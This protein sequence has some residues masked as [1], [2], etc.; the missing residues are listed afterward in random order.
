MIVGYQGET[1]LVLEK[2]AQLSYKVTAC[3]P[4]VT[5]WGGGVPVIPHPPAVGAG[6]CMEL[7]RAHR[8]GVNGVDLTE[9]EDIKKRW[10]EYTEEL[11][12]KIFRTQIT[13]M[14]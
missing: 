4:A 12:R 9:V 7:N 8:C 1:C 2:T 11:Y 13:M 10:Q 14:V 6:I 5:G 3:I